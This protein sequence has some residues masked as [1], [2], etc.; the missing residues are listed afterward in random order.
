MLR[1]A[2]SSSTTS[3]VLPGGA[4]TSSAPSR[5]GR[6]NRGRAL[7]VGEAAQLVPIAL[8]ERQMQLAAAIR[9]ATCDR[10]RVVADGERGHEPLPIDEAVFDRQLD[11]GL[12][13]VEGLRQRCETFELVND[14]LHARHQRSHRSRLAPVHGNQILEPVS[15]ALRVRRGVPAKTRP[16]CAMPPI[17]AAATFVRQS[18]CRMQLG[19]LGLKLAVERALGRLGDLSARNSRLDGHV[20]GSRKMG[21]RQPEYIAA[22]GTAAISRAITPGDA[23]GRA[24][25][26]RA[27]RDHQKNQGL[28]RRPF[29]RGECL[30]DHSMR[31]VDHGSL[32]AGGRNAILDA[33]RWRDARDRAGGEPVYWSGPTRRGT[34]GVALRLSGFRCGRWQ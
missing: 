20:R 8:F 17:T 14:S 18:S 24:A 12:L 15:V 9:D 10:G 13:G 31:L 29:E 32:E 11:V 28:S 19:N 1:M 25:A 7:A 4:D 30:L 5:A 23:E 3:T 26:R 16:I 34:G 22:L 2:G 33:A 21:A 27:Q 6:R